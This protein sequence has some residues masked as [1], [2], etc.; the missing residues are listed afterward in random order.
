M[1]CVTLFPPDQK[2]M[3]FQDAT[4]LTLNEGT[5]MFFACKEGSETSIVRH[6]T[7]MP[8]LWTE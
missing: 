2:P 3:N 6:I 8:F 5:L 4:E 1:A 7:N